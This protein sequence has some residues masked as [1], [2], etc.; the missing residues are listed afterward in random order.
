MSRLWS[1]LFLILAGTQ[2]PGITHAQNAFDDLP[3]DDPSK[4]SILKPGEDPEK[5]I[6]NN[7]FIVTTIDHRDCYPGQQVLLSYRL[8][9]ALHSSS[10]VTSKP[11][12]NGF[13]IKERKP[14]DALHVGSLD[15]HNN[16]PDPG[17]CGG[18]RL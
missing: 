15:F 14:D 18:R 4:R 17:R 1:I 12:L 2:I 9:T 3:I 8:Y 6:K 7:I 11:L 16:E 13:T 5:K 10:V